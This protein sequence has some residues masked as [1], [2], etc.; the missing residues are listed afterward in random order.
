MEE[1][2]LKKQINDRIVKDNIIIDS[3]IKELADTMSGKSRMNYDVIDAFATDINQIESICKYLDQPIPEG[4]CEYKN[5]E[6]CIDYIAGY[7]GISKRHIKL[8][9]KWWRD[10]D[11]VLLTKRKDNG[12]LCALFPGAL[13]GYYYIDKETGD[14]IHV[15]RKNRHQFEENA[16]CFYKPLPNKSLTKMEYVRFLLGRIKAYDVILVIIASVVLILLGLLTPRVT[17]IAFSQVVPSGKAALLI[18]LATLLLS[19]AGASWLITAVKSSLFERLKTRMNVASENAIFSRVLRLPADFFTDKSSG[20]LAQQINSLNYV[21]TLLSWDLLGFAITLTSSL[22]Y[23]IQLI[24]I[25]NTLLVPSLIVFGLMVIVLGITMYQE[26]KLMEGQLKY[27]KENSAVVY[28]FI[29][30]V[31][32]IKVSGSEKRAYGKWLESYKRK[33]GFTFA[34]KFPDFMRSNFITGIK[35]AGLLWF[36]IIAH[37][38]HISIA[39]FAAFNS[40]FGLAMAGFDSMAETGRMLSSLKPSLD[41]GEDILSATPE[42]SDVG[43]LVTSLRGNIDLNNVRFKYTENGPNI[44]DG[45]SLS[46]NP[47]EYVAFVGKSGCGKSTLIKLMLG[48]IKPDEGAIYYDNMDIDSLDK[49]SLRRSIGVVMQNGKLFAGDVLSNITISAPWLTEEDAWKAAEMAGMDEDIRLMP[50]GMYT[51]VSEGSGGISGGQRQR[52]IIAR[53]LAPNP[54]I[55]I[56]DEATSAL[57]NITQKKVTESL[58]NL[59]CTRIVIA[60]RLSTIRECDRIIALDKGKIVEQGSYDELMEKGGYFAELVSMQLI[61]KE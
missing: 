38:N 37:K 22:V 42:V 57:D 18:P 27:S 49:Q 7:S 2:G 39:E 51:M 53:A 32:K 59:D 45:L 21:P 54:N 16:W 26:W 28:D 5:I 44:V 20:G 24:N 25:A 30:G 19:T 43:K 8:D 13:W 6:D 3:G 14:K 58:N 46:I 9:D 31:E 60:H 34:A 33:A 12:E 4:E 55:L 29:S 17:Q 56:F 36:Y 50:K 48:F 52:L 23:L 41:A 10:G 1:Y 40:A 47:G 11:G 15:T 35:Y 61:D